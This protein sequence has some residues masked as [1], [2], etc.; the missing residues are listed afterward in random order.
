[1]KRSFALLRMTGT[2]FVVMLGEAKDPFAYRL[3]KPRL[4]S[5]LLFC[6]LMTIS[7]IHWITRSTSRMNWAM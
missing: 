1:M 7:R 3:A 6:I 5:L 4:Y 2:Q